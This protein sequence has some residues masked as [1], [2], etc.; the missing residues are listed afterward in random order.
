MDQRDFNK[1]IESAKSGNTE[2]LLK[3]LNSEQRAMLDKVMSDKNEA[4][5]LLSSPQAAAILKALAG[6]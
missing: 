5:K 4:K 2:Q 6:K 1:A 3:S